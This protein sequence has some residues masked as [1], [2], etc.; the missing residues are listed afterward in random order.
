MFA[1]YQHTREVMSTHTPI[2]D[3]SLTQR[4]RFSLAPKRR[5]SITL[6]NVDSTYYGMYVTPDQSVLW[7]RTI[8]IWEETIS[9]EN[10]NSLYDDGLVQVSTG[11][12]SVLR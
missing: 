8:T 5:K 3:Q 6:D 9:I 1:D 11:D 7:E 4:F 10:W 12:T 2:N